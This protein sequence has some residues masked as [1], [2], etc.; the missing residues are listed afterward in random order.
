M[1]NILSKW[2]V[3]AQ[4]RRL[5]VGV[6]WFLR[7]KQRAAGITADV[8]LKKSRFNRASVAKAG[9]ASCYGCLHHHAAAAIT[10]YAADTTTAICPVCGMDTLLAGTI[11][12]R[13]LERLNVS[14]FCR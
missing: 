8:A 12:K 3:V 6:K 2:R 11:P 13:Q 14:I 9:S 5:T 7:Q 1:K 4:V 10:E